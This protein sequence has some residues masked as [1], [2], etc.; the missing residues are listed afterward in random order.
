M[1]VGSVDLC[2][3]LEA[4]LRCPLIFFDQLGLEP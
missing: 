1:I 4:C 2:A 3:Y